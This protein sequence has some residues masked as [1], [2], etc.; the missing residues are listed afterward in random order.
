MD[1]LKEL[2]ICMYRPHPGAGFS[3]ELSYWMLGCLEMQMLPLGACAGTD[4]GRSTESCS[5]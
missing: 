5:P 2:N 1:V 3:E 4:R